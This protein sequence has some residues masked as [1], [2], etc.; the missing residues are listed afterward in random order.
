MKASDLEAGRRALDT[1]DS[2]LAKRPKKDNRALFDATA[3]L[4]VYRD[5]LIADA[6]SDGAERRERL[7]HVNAV[8]S[9]VAGMHYP[10]GEM[11]WGELEKARGWL[12]DLLAERAG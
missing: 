9:V 12:A 4:C 11:P 5:G 1:L 8:L 3:L 2:A 10:L 7:S 6:G